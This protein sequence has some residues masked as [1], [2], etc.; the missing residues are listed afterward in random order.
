MAMY[1]WMP[2]LLV[3]LLLTGCAGTDPTPSPG[4]VVSATD[5]DGDFE[6]TLSTDQT[7]HPAGEPIDI[8]TVLRYD[9]EPSDV[10]VWGSGS[11]LVVFSIGQLDGDLAMG[12]EKTDDCRPYEIRSG[13]PLSLPYAKGIAFSEDDPN[14]GFYMDWLN[15]PDF[16][17]P[18]GAWR[19]WASADFA[20]GA[21][22]GRPVR[23][24]TSIVITV[25]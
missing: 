23:L 15:D 10:T 3:V 1:R 13:E 21:C 16:T 9:G 5:R 8:E 19:M 18:A 17:L 11:G 14:A 7:V 2:L 25:R 6:L 22:E 4:A 12:G 20:L 24:D